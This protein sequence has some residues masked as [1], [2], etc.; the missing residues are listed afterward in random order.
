[1]L[2]GDTTPLWESDT[3]F[4]CRYLTCKTQSHIRLRGWQRRMP[5]LECH[6]EKTDRVHVPEPFDCNDRHYMRTRKNVAE[7]KSIPDLR[8]VLLRNRQTLLRL[9]TLQR[10]L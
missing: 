9:S 5:Y 10:P 7:S 8:Y 3:M 6:V 4:L 2:V 1:M